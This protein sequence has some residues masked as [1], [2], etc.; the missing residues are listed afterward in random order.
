MASDETWLEFQL[1]RSR[2]GELL[3]EALASGESSNGDAQISR[4]DIRVFA[5]GLLAAT[6]EASA[7]ALIKSQIPAAKAF[8]QL[9]VRRDFLGEERIPKPDIENPEQLGR[10]FYG[11]LHPAAGSRI[12]KP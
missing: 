1:Q 9:A 2:F 10:P 11:C 8:Q 3:A 6:A 4:G 12:Q 5:K 7:L